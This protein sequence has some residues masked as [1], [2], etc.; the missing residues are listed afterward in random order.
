MA[1][2]ISNLIVTILALVSSNSAITAVTVKNN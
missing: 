2:G 1:L